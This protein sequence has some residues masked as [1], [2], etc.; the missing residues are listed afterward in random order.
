VRTP[1]IDST[2]SLGKSLP[3]AVDAIKQR[4]NSEFEGERYN[5]AIYLYNQAI[6]MAPHLA[7]LYGNRAAAF[8][9]RNW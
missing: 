8:L 4:A 6:S 7:V 3:P 2:Q 5:Q 9:K 1:A